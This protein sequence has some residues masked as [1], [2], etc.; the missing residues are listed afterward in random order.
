MSQHPSKALSD[1]SE[2]DRRR[3]MLSAP[4]IS[5]LSALANSL[6]RANYYVPDFD[7]CDGGIDADILFLF[8]KPGPK[9]SPPI[10]S[11]FIS[12]DNNDPTAEAT[13][14]FMEQAGIDRKRSVIWNVIPGWNETVTIA[15]DELREGR[16]KLDL[17]LPLLCKLRTVVLVGRKAHSAE[18]MLAL[19]GLRIVRS[20]HPSMR[21]RNS[22]PD[23][24]REIPKEWAK[25]LA[26]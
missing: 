25:A 26:L 2:Q 22:M 21:V 10:G 24:W 3:A 1:P 7:P 14:S 6:R 23:R 15:R 17:L 13:K 20:Y 18:S 16:A 11:G 19:H 4:H 8:E 9:T 5:P 12:R